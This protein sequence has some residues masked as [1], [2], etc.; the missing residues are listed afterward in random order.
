MI[1]ALLDTESLVAFYSTREAWCGWVLEQIGTIPLLF[2]Y[3]RHGRQLIPLL[4]PGF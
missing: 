2:R 3:R 1:K 4:S